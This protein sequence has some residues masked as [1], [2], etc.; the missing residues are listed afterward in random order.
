LTSR[1]VLR[2]ERVL[3]PVEQIAGG[4]VSIGDGKVQAVGPVSTV[5]VPAG[6]HVVDCGD[7]TIIPGFIDVHIHGSGGDSAMDGPDAVVRIAEFVTRF[8]VTSWLPTLT[9]RATIKDMADVIQVNLDAGPRV[10]RGAEF[11]GLHLEGPFL[12]PKRPGAIRSEWFRE[13]SMDDL[14]ALLAAGKGRIRLMT[15][16]PELPG[17]LD[18]VRRLVSSGVVA[19]IG[20]SDA[21]HDQAMAAIEAGVT[22]ATH[23]FNAMRGF[24][25]R[26]PGVAGVV[27][28]SEAVRCELIADGVHV[29]PLA[30]RLLIKSKSPFGVV[31]ITDAVAPAGLGDGSYAFDG[32]PI[33]VRD[34]KATLADGTIAGSVATFDGNLRR[35]VHECGVPLAQAVFMGTW[36]PA[37]AVGAGDRKGYLGGGRDADLVVLDADLRV[38]L[39]MVRGQVVFDTLGV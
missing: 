36:V 32:R 10:S 6:A 31:L 28:I 37:R 21:T 3:T 14:D 16:A 30:M 24:Q 19:S 12:S 33:T 11:L 9:P 25:H 13:P 38:R 1:Y 4:A 39:T 27:M 5:D 23:T 8:G 29:D 2:A 20:H 18:L 17:G 15:L 35:I 22:H 34:G 26:D 7:A